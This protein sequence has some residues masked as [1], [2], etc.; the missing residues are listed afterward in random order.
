MKALDGEEREVK[1]RREGREA[2][3]G[4]EGVVDIDE[5]LWMGKRRREAIDKQTYHK[6]RSFY[7]ESWL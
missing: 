7:V 4:G 1:R 3:D 6:H 5:G 2:I